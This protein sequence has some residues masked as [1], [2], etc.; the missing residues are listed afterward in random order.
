MSL[1]Q[2]IN[3]ILGTLAVFFVL[4]E[5]TFKLFRLYKTGDTKS[6]NFS[7]LF[8]NLSALLIMEAF[9]IGLLFE[10]IKSQQTDKPV[11]MESIVM[12]LVDIMGNVLTITVFVILIVSKFLKK[13]KFHIMWK[14]YINKKNIIISCIIIGLVSIFLVLVLIL[15][16]KILTNF[17]NETWI[18]IFSLLATILF[19][20]AS[21]PQALQTII[22][23]DTNALSLLALFSYL[24]AELMWF[25]YDVTQLLLTKNSELLP[26]IIE[27]LVL[28]S[29]VLP[30][31]IIKFINLKRDKTTILTNKKIQRN[32]TE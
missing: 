6:Y 13:D 30:L 4:T 12:Q 2:I 28:V 20:I 21:T 31:V 19:I 25:G 16:R 11:P 7:H 27:D 10:W 18:N 23:R 22:T 26:E 5:A 24:S 15:Q 29:L 3:V 32:K 17:K 1:E 14:E 8:I 9:Q